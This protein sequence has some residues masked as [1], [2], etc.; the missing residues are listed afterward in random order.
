MKIQ[1]QHLV[2]II[3]IILTSLIACNQK[4]VLQNDVF[5]ITLSDN[6]KMV[7]SD[8]INVSDSLI[9]TENF[10]IN[11]WYNTNIPTTV[12]NALQQNGLYKNV[13]NGTALEDLD[14]NIFKSAWWYRHKFTIKDLDKHFNLKIDGINQYADVWINGREI[15]DSSQI[16]NP[17]RQYTL[18]LDNYL[19]KGE[20]VIALKIYPPKKGDYN[21]GF[22]DW[23]PMAPDQEMGITRPIRLLTTNE[24]AIDQP[25]I[26]SNFKNN[27]YKQVD[28][29][30]SVLLKNFVKNKTQGILKLQID[31]IIIEK[32][33][34]LS[35]LEEKV[36]HLNSD[37]FTQLTINNPKLWWPHTIG[38]P[39]LYKAKISFII[40]NQESDSKEVNFGIRE[41][42]DYFTKDGHR[43]FKINGEKILIRGGGWVDNLSLNNTDDNIKAQLEY[44]K[45]LNFN[46]IR[47]EG[48]WG[49][50]QKMYDLCDQMGILVMVGWSC[51]WEWENYI[52]KPVDEDYG[53][54]TSDEDID[55]I[56]NAWKD[57]IIWLRNHPS[58]FTWFGGSDKIPTPKLEKKYFE[59]FDKYDTTRV[60]LSSAKEWNSLAGPSGVKMR[61]PYEVEPPVY[62]FEDTKFGGAFGFNT[63]T[64]PGAQVPPLES[65]KKMIPKEHLWPIDSVWDYHCGRNEF[66]SL[67]RYNKALF[68]RYGHMSSVEEY[69]FKAQ[70]MNYELMRSMFEAFSIKRYEATGVI[71]WMLNS[72]WPEMYWQ[73]YDYYLMP[74]GAYYGAK[75][76]NNSVHTV[77]DYAQNSI[78]IANDKLQ[79]T[80]NLQVSISAFDINSKL[81]FT[82]AIDTKVKANS[83]SKILDLPDLGAKG[84]YFLS[85]KTTNQSKETID[86]NFYWLSTKK[87]I[88]NYQDSDWYFTPFKQ[89]A[90]FT[91]LNTMK[92]VHIEHEIS[93]E[94]N[95]IYRTFTVTLN[96]TT[97]NIAFFINTKLIN[98][99]TGE[100]IL[101]VIWSDNYISLVP[102]EKRTLV[103]RI[104]LKYL[105]NKD[106]DFELQ[107]WNN[108]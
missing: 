30:A 13:Y 72:A 100:Q 58:I 6:W 69:A 25:Y 81:I 107:A 45:D 18:S 39:N 3:S 89:Y 83:S 1:N 54:I 53:A 17:F 23:N 94:D 36:I 42:S 67:K 57:Q 8:K 78:F 41:V 80:E 99:A 62:W 35:P 87:D 66:N 37:E 40:N 102:L 11:N 5:G 50:S 9:S 26:Q 22:V 105:K 95:D 77:Y 20:N 52:G 85:I 106:I 104:K 70:A 97:N 49:K 16:K 73:L 55:L 31:D 90:N 64:G 32:N 82:K 68:N 27:N 44:V 71:Q 24:V 56:T 2:F 43:G 103:A 98:K 86:D 7:S 10:D 108:K 96:N 46:T 76:A 63:E 92:P 51:H 65:I 61:G 38:T 21:I 12:F 34:E 74:N 4:A 59:V 47:L 84:T 88:L 33:I 19:N 75:K 91:E 29:D 48:F 15:A 28:L 14:K 60:Y 93:I 101:P 79:D